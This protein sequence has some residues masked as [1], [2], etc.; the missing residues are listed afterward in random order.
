MIT[1][2]PY[3]SVFI[4]EGVWTRYKQTPQANPA[5]F[6]NKHGKKLRTLI[7]SA[8]ADRPAH[9]RGLSGPRTVWLQGRTIRWLFLVPN[10]E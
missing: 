1:N 3:T 4:K 10:R 2:R 6:V 8:R 9:M 5:N 7:Y